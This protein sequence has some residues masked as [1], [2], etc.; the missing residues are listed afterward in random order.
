ML[1]Y[2]DLK[3]DLQVHTNNTDGKMTIEEMAYYAKEKFGLDYIAISDHTK[4]LKITNGLDEEQILN[5]AN[6]ITELNDKIK[7]DD[8]FLDE[9]N[10]EK[11]VYKN[12][13]K[14]DQRSNN[15][16]FRIL[17]SAEVNILKDGSLDI[18]NNVLDKLDIVGA[19]IHS[20]FSLPMKCKHIGLLQP[21]KILV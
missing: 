21:L 20:N 15:T 18:S 12:N 5:Q 9:H 2:H 13:K 6:I 17:S 1:D 8:F 4:S 10:N 11:S 14:Y 16:S 19:T 3:G 7:S